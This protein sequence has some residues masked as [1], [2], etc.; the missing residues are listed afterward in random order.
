MKFIYSLLLLGGMLTVAM[1]TANWG[2]DFSKLTRSRPDVRVTWHLPEVSGG[3][4][5]VDRKGMTRTLSI[6][7][8]EAAALQS[9]EL[10]VD[11][12]LP[13]AST[14]LDGVPPK[15]ARYRIHLVLA[16]GTR[17]ETRERQSDWNHLD[18]NMARTVE[19]SL[20]EY[21]ELRK[22]HDLRGPIREIKNF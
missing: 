7:E 1:I 20:R 5:S 16:D 9:A 17:L 10:L 11:R 13:T 4:A 3:H 2:V 15:Q 14:R 22:K 21:R 12:K 8:R 19:H 6:L 18:A